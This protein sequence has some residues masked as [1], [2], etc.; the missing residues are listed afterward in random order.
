VA[1]GIPIAVDAS[2]QNRSLGDE[3]LDQGIVDTFVSTCC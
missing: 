2:N 3:Q 1:V